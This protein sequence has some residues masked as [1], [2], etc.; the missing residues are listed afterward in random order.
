MEEYNKSREEVLTNLNVEPI[1]IEKG[2]Y[3]IAPEREEV[4]NE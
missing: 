2:V 1:E 3:D 4:I